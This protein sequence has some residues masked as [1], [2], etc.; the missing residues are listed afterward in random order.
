MK[1]KINLIEQI[2]NEHND[3]SNTIVL[4][5]DSNSLQT[6]LCNKKNDKYCVEIENDLDTTRVCYNMKNKNDVDELLELLE[7]KFN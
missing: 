6:L 5:S 2:I 3:D 4:F 1:K 7:M